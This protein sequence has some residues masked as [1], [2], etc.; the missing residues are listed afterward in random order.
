MPNFIITEPEEIIEINSKLDHL[1]SII[2]PPQ[3]KEWL[4]SDEVCQFLGIS[5]RCL[6]NYKTD[7]VIG[8]SDYFGKHHFKHSEIIEI[9][10]RNYKPPFSRN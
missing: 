2:K 3:D 8:Y 6:Q 1:L 7:G 10:N 5:Q 4:T 9:L